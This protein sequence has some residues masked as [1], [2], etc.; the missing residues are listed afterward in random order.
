MIGGENGTHR[1]GTMPRHLLS[2]VALALFPLS[3]SAQGVPQGVTDSSFREF[4]Q[5]FE[6]ATLQMINGDA[7]AWRGLESHLGD[8]SLLSP[9]GPVYAGPDSVDAQYAKVGERYLPSSKT[10]I[11]FEYVSAGASGDMGYAVILQHGRSQRASE[12][13]MRTTLTRA[14]NIFRREGGSWKLVHRHMDHLT[15]ARCKALGPP[16]C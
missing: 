10:M 6:S 9:Y 1:R 8:V 12:D 5:E 14:T 16:G 7:S 4:L 13:T 3:G 15:P 2:L 11:E